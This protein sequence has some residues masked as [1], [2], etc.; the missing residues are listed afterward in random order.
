MQ[1]T[2][3]SEFKLLDYSNTGKKEIYIL[4]AGTY[5]V[6]RIPCPSGHDCFWYVLSGTKIGASENSLR[7][8]E[9][10]SFENF[11]VDFDFPKKETKWF[12]VLSVD[13]KF[14]QFVDEHEYER[15]VICKDSAIYGTLFAYVVWEWDRFSN[16]TEAHVKFETKDFSI[17]SHLEK[18]LSKMYKDMPLDYLIS[19]LEEND[20]VNITEHK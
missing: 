18:M 5:E 16:F 6:E 9:D 20:F 10:S 3:Y 11:R 8:W 12:K 17:F 1:I 14:T 15:V 13:R 4:S 7:M 19:L 2:T